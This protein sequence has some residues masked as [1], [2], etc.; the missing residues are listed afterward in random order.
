V[1]AI[2]TRLDVEGSCSLFAIAPV[3]RSGA[4][5]GRMAT[6]PTGRGGS[7]SAT[8]RSR[9]VPMSRPCERATSPV[10]ALFRPRSGRSAVERLLAAREHYELVGMVPNR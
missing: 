9:R 1:T 3:V 4:A 8:T 7:R 2:M 10:H 5:T 6:P